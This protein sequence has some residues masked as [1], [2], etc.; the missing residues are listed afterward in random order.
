MKKYRKLLSLILTSMVIVLIV[1][2]IMG[3]KRNEASS[4]GEWTLNWSDEF[5][6]NVIDTDKW[7]FDTG[8]GF[9]SGDQWVRGWG[10]E[11]LEY[12][13]EEN[14]SVEEGHLI[15][16]ARNDIEKTDEHGTYVF[17]SSKLK[18]LGLF[19]QK[20]GRFESRMKLPKGK[21]LWPAFWMLPRD[22]VYGGWAASGEIDIMENGG[23]NPGVIGGAI[24]YGSVWPENTYSNKEFRF[25][26]G[27]DITD[28]H[29]YALEW[30]PGE[31][32]WYVDGE[33]YL[34]LN[35]WFTKFPESE[36]I[37]EFPAPF[38]Q[39]FYI[40]LNLAVGGWYDG[41]PEDDAIFPGEMV[42]DYVRVYESR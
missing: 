6:G 19:S 21:G 11:E 28:F 13:S 22:E 8:N 31:I 3:N 5:D 32:R 16:R 18:T 7:G 26:E 2:V 20:F 30:E 33:N 12:Y 38:D 39:E 4:E 1:A 36:I 23:S 27:E 25:P 41:D 10:N 14:A 9:Y 17:T 35:K 15:I 42:V 37:S 29:T 40:I 34:T 24:H